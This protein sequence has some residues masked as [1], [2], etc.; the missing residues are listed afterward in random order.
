MR[1]WQHLW[2]T[3]DGVVPVSKYA[4]LGCIP[5]HIPVGAL[6][7][8]AFEEDPFV[9]A[10]LQVVPVGL[11]GH[12]LHRKPVTL[13]CLIPTLAQQT[14]QRTRQRVTPLSDVSRNKFDRRLDENA[15]IQKIGDFLGGW[16][17]DVTTVPRFE[18]LS[19]KNRKCEV[20][21]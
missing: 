16:E 19:K 11:W 7:I 17:R 10:L 21:I 5:N 8:H 20:Q 9:G 12:P 13:D 18:G 4:T 14:Y 2:L 1:V 3:A 15:S 6:A